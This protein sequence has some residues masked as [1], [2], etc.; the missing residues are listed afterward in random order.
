M[1]TLCE[2]E[3]GSPI[4]AISASKDGRQVAALTDANGLAVYNVSPNGTVRLAS[5]SDLRSIL[6]SPIRQE[7]DLAFHP[8]SNGIVIIGET[9]LTEGVY[10]RSA[11]AVLVLS[12]YGQVLDRYITIEAEPPYSSPV[13]TDTNPPMLLVGTAS[14]VLYIDLESGQERGRID[15]DEEY[16]APRGVVPRHRDGGQVFVIWTYQ[17]GSRISSYQR[18]DDSSFSALH[19]GDQLLPFY[20]WGAALNQDDSMLA[21]MLGNISVPVVEV[22]NKISTVSLGQ[23]RLYDP[24]SHTLLSQYDVSGQAGSDVLLQQVDSLRPN[25]SGGEWVPSRSLVPKHHLSNPVFVGRDHVVF[26]TPGG[27]V[28]VLNVHTGD[29]WEIAITSSPITSLAS[30]LDSTLL[31]IG[32]VGGAICFHSIDS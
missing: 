25:A 20:V 18:Q 24:D 30:C 6:P 9:T 8:S 21:I 2:Y 27:T 13:V 4:I 11:L 5:A 28:R 26:G 3:L 32:S 14:G 31:C 23:I 10:V 29:H 7:R 19:E 15:N 12:Q 16:V 22:D 17:S 1:G